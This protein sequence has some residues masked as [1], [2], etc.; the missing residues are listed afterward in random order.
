M[1]RARVLVVNDDARLAQTVSTFLSEE[2]FDTRVVSNGQAAIDTLAWW[3]ADVVLLDLIMPYLDGW[4]F[5]KR[6]AS[7][8]ALARPLVVVWSVAAPE[9][10][11]R[12][13]DL[14]AAECLPG[15]ATGPDRLLC[16]VKDLLESRHS[17]KR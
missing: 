17:V 16:A 10:L 4:G 9:E 3:P 5:L 2:G 1:A 6:R 8:P 11:E 15:G 7:E 12:A 13:R 14:G